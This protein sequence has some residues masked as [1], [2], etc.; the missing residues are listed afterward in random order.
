[1]DEQFLLQLEL[2]KRTEESSYKKN[3]KFS[4]LNQWLNNAGL[5]TYRRMGFT[6][7]F[8]IAPRLFRFLNSMLNTIPYMYRFSHVLLVIGRKPFNKYLT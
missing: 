1:M 8:S 6:P 7:D 4:N 3:V 5:E 2:Q